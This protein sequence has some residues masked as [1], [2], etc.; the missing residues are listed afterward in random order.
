MKRQDFTF[1]LPKELIAS[2]PC[3]NRSGSRLLCVNGSDVVH[4]KFSDLPDLLNE[5]DLLIFNDSKVMQ[6]RIYGYKDTGGKA[7]ILVERVL[8]EGRVLAHLK[9][10]NSKIGTVILINDDI[11]II[12][13]G[14]DEALFILKLVNGRDED[15]DWLE[16]MD[17]YG[18]MPIPPYM[19]REDEEFDNNRYQTIYAKKTGSAAAPTAGLHFDDDIFKRLEE[20]G[21]DKAFVTLHVGSGTFLPVRV[22]DIKDHVMHSE[23]IEVSKE[24]CDKIRNV[25]KKGGRVIA[26]GTTSVRCL[27]TAAKGGEL[28]PYK[29]E[30]DI[31]IYPGYKFNSVDMMITNFH[32]PE[33]TLLMLVSAF[34]GQDNIKEAYE[35][36]IKERYR[37]FSY[38]DAMLLSPK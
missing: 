13:E 5:G 36:A 14:R 19:E 6:A 37:F 25:R 28:K 8:E 1:D 26:V 20:K 30:T 29:G 3:E 21:I 10:T 16:I 18:H 15:K 9:T 17:K 27:E 12:V 32:L 4:K 2:R 7:E 31:F 23:I 11:E 38:G 34:A 35:E 24:V 33:S 22:D